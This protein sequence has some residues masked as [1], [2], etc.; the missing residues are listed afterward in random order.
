M[1]QFDKLP[2][3]EFQASTVVEKLSELDDLLHTLPPDKRHEFRV[4]IDTMLI[5]A[6][7]SKDPA[8]TTELKQVVEEIIENIKSQK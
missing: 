2:T 6:L 3:P 1:S 5:N 8:T 7:I 4:Q